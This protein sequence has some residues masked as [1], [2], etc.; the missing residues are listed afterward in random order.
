MNLRKYTGIARYALYDAGNSN[1]DTLVVALAFPLFVRSAVVADPSRADLVWGIMAAGGTLLAAILG[2]KVGALV[3]RTGG[4]F[5]ALRWLSF[6]AIAGTFLLARLPSGGVVVAGGLFV[7]TQCAF[8]LAA[9][10]YNSALADVSTRRNAA[11]IS[12]AAWGVGYLGGLVGLTIALL[13]RNIHPPDARL[14][15]LF[16]VAAGMFL[17][18]AL[19]LVMMRRK[20]TVKLRGDRPAQ[21]L[22]LIPLLRSFMRESRRSRLFWAFFLYMNGVNT[23]VYFTA[24]Y[25]KDR[26]GFDLD[27]LIGLFII[28]NIVAAPASIIVG[29]VTERFGQ[30]RTLKVVVGAWVAVVVLICVAGHRG[31]RQM[32]TVVACCAA[33][34]LG[35]VQALS[36]SLFRI[37]FPDD[38]MSSYFGVQSL[39]N[40]SAALVGPLL[41]GL[42]SWATRSQIIGALSA[43]ALFASGLVVL[44]LVPKDIEFAE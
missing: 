21:S 24:I 41:F 18:F 17:V 16:V 40:R 20:D 2:P 38:A 19:P 15:S 5:R 42:V 1:Y 26:L 28:M 3:D 7:V 43:G 23:V 13:T 33:S 35:P 4:K 11:V 14:R 25:A 10:L 27:G 6:A 8:L 36:R 12:S 37:I 31:D 30:L 44:L 29:K 39:A 22:W 34:L 32:F 9:L